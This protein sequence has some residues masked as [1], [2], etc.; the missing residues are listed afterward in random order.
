MRA[1]SGFAGRSN[2]VKPG[3]N[4]PCLCG[5]GKKYKH[6]HGLQQQAGGGTVAAASR[7]LATKSANQ[8]TDMALQYHR[9][10]RLI[11]ADAL[12]AQILSSHPAHADATHLRGLIAHQTGRHVEAVE[13]VSRAIEAGETA[14]MHN[15]LAEALSALG[16]VGEAIAHYRRALE[17]DDGYEDAL[18]NLGVAL[19]RSGAHGEAEA[20]LKKAINRSPAALNPRTNLG[21]LYQELDRYDEAIKQYRIAL[22]MAPED[23]QTHNNLGNAFREIGRLDQALASYHHAISLEPG[24][25]EAGNN[26]AVGLQLQGR[27]GEAL[28]EF[29]RALVLRPGNPDA[30]SNRALAYL[31]CGKFPQGW[32]DYEFRFARS[33]NRPVMRE[34]SQAP[35]TG[36]SLVG[37]TLR[38]W[39]E[40][41][42]GDEIWAAG[43]IPELLERTRLGELI[44]ECRPKLVAL[45]QRSFKA[46]EVLPQTMPPQPGA[47]QGVDFQIACGSLG[48]FLRPGAVNFPSREATWGAYLF[49]DAERT[50]YWRGQLE[51]LGK[52]LKVG[53]CWRSSD[54]KGE[55]RLA[56]T[57]LIQ[58][59]SLFALAGITWVN[60]QYDESEAELLEAERAFG[61]HILRYPELDMFD[62]LDE[63]AALMRNLDLIISA[64]TTVSIQAG[65]LG[66][67]VWQMHYGAYWQGHGT[68]DNP[69]YPSMRVFHRQWDEP[70][71]CV[72]ERIANAL[73]NASIHEVR[74]TA[75]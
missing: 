38:I 3:P 27:M 65:A 57:R 26:L 35:W 39:G 9:M 68:P 59:G 50:S 8:L 16:R 29:D 67:P 51:K 32:R 7:A 4:D 12:Y 1:A 28:E 40:Q 25:A 24:Y 49:A 63:T 61:V 14:P 66:V 46:A 18:N 15:N 31:A 53:I 43:M 47:L 5:S 55:R 64:P 56:C 62:D 45:F 69:W 21:N 11:E 71:E 72:L 36:E 34:L 19:T 73:S 30:V 22:A 23:A 37:K 33:A 10:G 20:V 58:W 44:I 60:L 13:W 70:W 54:L 74:V 41:G 48:A 42:V 17:L 52:G 6:C 2:T 75:N